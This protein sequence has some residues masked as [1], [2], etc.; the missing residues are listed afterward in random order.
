MR[1][2]HQILGPFFPL[3]SIPVTQGDLT[4]RGHAEGEIIEVTGRVLND[5]GEP[6]PAARLT[7]WQANSFGRYVHPNDPNPAPL[8]PNFRGFAI[9]QSGYDGGY[10]IKTVKP[11]PYPVGPDW[12][13]APHIHFEVSGQFERLITQMY[14][15]GE[16][17][18]ASDRLLMSVANPDLLIAKPLPLTQDRFGVLQFD[19]V[20]ARG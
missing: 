3:G 14:F 1:T 9:L 6:I 7:I 12:M 8:D 18:N 2:P 16:P 11:G 19:I 13:R 15:P 17:L 4:E 10:W 20:L 5:K